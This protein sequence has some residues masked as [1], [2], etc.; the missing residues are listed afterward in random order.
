MHQHGCHN[1][2]W[3]NKRRVGRW[4]NWAKCLCY[5]KSKFRTHVM[6][7]KFMSCLKIFLCIPSKVFIIIIMHVKNPMV[8]S[9][10]STL[11]SSMWNELTSQI[12]F[13]LMSQNAWNQGK[14]K[15]VNKNESCEN[16]TLLIIKK[17]G[18]TMRNCVCQNHSTL[19]QKLKKNSYT[20]I[21]QLS[22]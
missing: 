3:N 7:L 9:L 5:T 2:G 20:T 4:A 19:Q 14:F 11:G 13:N 10:S 17:S 16:Q 15:N 8:C 18:F 6:Q 12:M 22:L 1:Y 21:V